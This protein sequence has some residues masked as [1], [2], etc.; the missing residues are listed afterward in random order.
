MDV[1]WAAW[2]R[3]FPALDKLVYLNTAGGAAMSRA[4]AAAGKQYFDEIL[5]GGDAHW[6]VWLE[7]TEQVRQS[8]AA[9]L[10]A[11]PG[12]VAF[13]PTAS[14]GMNL[15][16]QMLARPGGRILVADREFP[17]ATLPW[18]NLGAELTVLPLAED[19]SV[20]LD[21]IERQI[22]D[23]TTA[24]VA[25]H[26][27]YQTGFRYDLGAL[28]KICERHGLRLIVDATQSVGAW[29]IDVTRDGIDALVFSGY[30]WTTAGYGVAGLY[31]SQA[32][33]DSVRLPVVGW[34][35]ARIPSAMA[36]D[37]LDLARSAHALEAGH[38]PF[39]GIFA[40][41]ASLSLLAEIGVARIA[42]RI[43]ALT[44][45]LHDGLAAQGYAVASPRDPAVRSG[46][47]LVPV[48]GG[49]A[50]G[51]P[52]AG[53]RVCLQRRRPAAGLLAFLQRRDRHRRLAR[54]AAG[55][56]CG[57]KPRALSPPRRPPGR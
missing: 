33:L 48:G 17:S 38:P 51:A 5:E 13:M 49:R 16:A 26:V 2:R 56:R 18:L 34:R 32:L 55:T 50:E 3:E 20:A 21:G 22:D 19:G 53:G 41:G 24:I 52:H 27:Q 9:L 42:G 8:L 7:R 37:R 47:T 45:T 43:D 29:P 44:A 1:D 15:V 23:R 6:P 46:I 31:V 14:L 35:S 4:A 39:P 57:L 40:L 25:S 30:K 10:H 36:Y 11:T 12:E 28:G 54:A